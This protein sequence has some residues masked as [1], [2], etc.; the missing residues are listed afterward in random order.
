MENDIYE[1]NFK[2][3]FDLIVYYTNMHLF[4]EYE[5]FITNYV[6][7][8]TITLDD[9]HFCEDFFLDILSKIK[10]IIFHSN[11][12]TYKVPMPKDFFF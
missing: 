9:R 4:M 6:V 12:Y 10:F 5:I 2:N 7:E 11:K 1:N 8:M 3:P